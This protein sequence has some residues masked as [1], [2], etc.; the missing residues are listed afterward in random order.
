MSKV[1]ISV[2]IPFFNED[3]SVG[4]LH[5]WIKK[6]MDENIRKTADYFSSINLTTGQ[7][8][9]L[10]IGA[11]LLLFSIIKYPKYSLPVIFGLAATMSVF[12]T[13]TQNIERPEY[14][15]RLSIGNAD[16]Y[17]P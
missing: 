15:N 12:L 2:V 7:K 8:I 1:D 10:G 4:E 6:V 5:A 3:E 9:G 11:A 13:N 17:I 14:F 16:I